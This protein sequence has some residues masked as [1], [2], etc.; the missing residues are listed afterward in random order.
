MVNFQFF[1]YF[2]KIEKNTPKID[3]CSGLPVRSRI[4][5]SN[6]YYLDYGY[7]SSDDDSDDA[8][9]SAWDTPPSAWDTPLTIAPRNV[10][11]PTRIAILS[12]NSYHGQPHKN[13]GIFVQHLQSCKDVVCQ[14][15]CV[16][17]S[18][19]VCG[20]PRLL[21]LRAM[22][23]ANPKFRI[24]ADVIDAH[25]A[26][27]SKHAKKKARR[28]R[29][30]KPKRQSKVPGTHNTVI[31]RRSWK[32]AV[33]TLCIV[34]AITEVKNLR[35]VIR[36]LCKATRDYLP[37]E[38][39]RIRASLMSWR[40]ITVNS[41]L[42][43]YQH[44]ERCAKYVCG[45]CTQATDHT[46]YDPD[47]VVLTPDIFNEALHS[48]Q[49]CMDRVRQYRDPPVDFHDVPDAIRTVAAIQIQRWYRSRVANFVR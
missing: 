30:A 6:R 48:V 45:K 7:S 17:I 28:N 29:K 4:N 46:K 25:N 1:F 16:N 37:V 11:I 21:N 20:P 3:D 2:H 39:P 15:I 5:M 32:L 33:K 10:P 26:T 47:V 44:L 49:L 8:P 38:L 14:N 36:G 35:Y 22:A 27:T 31:P 41:L 19:G 42:Y 13:R 12:Q 9:P 34:G 24:C 18:Q 40:M 23:R 43:D